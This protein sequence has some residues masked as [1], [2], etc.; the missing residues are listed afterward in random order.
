MTVAFLMRQVQN[1]IAETLRMWPAPPLLIRCALEEDTWPEGG[2]GVEGG[3][4]LQRASDLFISL[5]DR[6]HSLQ[7]ITEPLPEPADEV[8]FRID[9]A[10]RTLAGHRYNPNPN[11][12]PN[13]A[14]HR[15]NMGRSPDLWE[16]PDVFD[17]SRWDRPFTNPKV[18]GW[19]GYNPSARKGLY[20]SEVATDYAFLAFGA[21]ERKCVGDQFALLEAAVT[22]I[23]MCRR[24]ALV[25]RLV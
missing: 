7:S 18:K 6:G 3:V 14:G 9:G 4:K 22:M 5:C 15:Y 12:N 8:G 11:P 1:V 19:K 21:G 13:L 23:M 17:T 2:T 20:P 10:G 24:R 25:G 16:H